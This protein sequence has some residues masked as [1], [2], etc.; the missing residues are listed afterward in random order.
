MIETVRAEREKQRKRTIA[1]LAASLLIHL[2]ILLAAFVILSLKPQ[3]LQRLAPTPAPTPAPAEFTLV[4]PP[5]PPKKEERD[6]LDSSQGKVSE[7]APKDAA[8]ES[9]QNMLAASERPAQSNAPVPT[10]DGEQGPGL[11]LRSQDLSLG[12]APKPSAPSPASPAH[13]AQLKTREKPPEEKPPDKATPTPA[14]T[15]ETTPP[16]KA[17]PTPRPTPRPED[18]ELA[19]LDP[20]RPHPRP[21][22]PEVRKPEQPTRPSV[23]R[24]PGYQPQTRVTRLTGGISNQGPASMNAVATPLG[25]YKKMLSDAIGSR[26]YYYVND[27]LDLVSVGTVQLRF[28]VRTDGS[29]ERCEVLKNTSN[30]S[31]ASCSV[32]SVMEAEIPPIPK[33]IAAT[34]AGGR[35]EVDYSFQIVGR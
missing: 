30:E 5:E 24:P 31:L 29:V 2:L 12:P 1:A 26:W 34:L 7:T 20:A 6:F 4:P 28:V 10:L 33:E 18:A 27:M 32:R 21:S 16:P 35:L 19:L 17:T 9:D 8:F 23:P 3:W 14:P 22:E 11:T 13:P 15:P 25:R